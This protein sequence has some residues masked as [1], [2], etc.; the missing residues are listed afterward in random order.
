MYWTDWGPAIRSIQRAN[1]DGSDRELLVNTTLTNPFGL[2]LDFTEHRMYWAE[3]WLD[4]FESS[5]MDG[6]NRELIY[7]EDGINPFAIALR[8]KCLFIYYETSNVQ[9]K[10]A[11]YI[12]MV[13]DV[14]ERLQ[15]PYGINFLRTSGSVQH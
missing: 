4:N 15:Q 8:G 3:A 6:D 1:L 14:S 13:T 10:H 9:Y 12:H 7:H 5:D 2:A 11:C